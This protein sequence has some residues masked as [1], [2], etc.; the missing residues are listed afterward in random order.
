M[1]KIYENDNQ[2]SVTESHII[3][4]SDFEAANQ[5]SDKYLPNALKL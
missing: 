3:Y 5:L 1:F 2:I 4:H